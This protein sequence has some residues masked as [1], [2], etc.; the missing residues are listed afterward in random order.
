MA[1]KSAVPP[2]QQFQVVNRLAIKELEAWFFGDVDALKAAYPR[3]SPTLG[4]RARYRNPD[5]ITGGTWEALERLL[6]RLNYFRQGLPKITVAREVSRHMDPARNRSRSF[7]VFREG[8]L[9]IIQ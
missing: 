9:T 1:T 5:A 7:Q 2:G 8:L 3:V 6:Q 4:Q